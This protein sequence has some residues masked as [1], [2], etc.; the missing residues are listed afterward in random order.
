MGQL[1]VITYELIYVAQATHR[2]GKYCEMGL[3]HG[4]Y[5]LIENILTMNVLSIGCDCGASWYILDPHE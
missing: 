1:V 3:L 2:Y 5:R 4:S